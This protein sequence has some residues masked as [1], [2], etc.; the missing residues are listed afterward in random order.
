[1]NKWRPTKLNSLYVIPD[2]HGQL[3]RLK[4]LCKTIL[5]LRKSDG[6]KDQLVFLGDYIDRG[7]KTPEL[8][9]Y[10]IEQKEIHKDRIVLLSGNHEQMFLNAIKQSPTSNKYLFWMNNGGAQTLSAYLDR[11][12]Q[13][14]D[15]PYEL[16]RTRVKDFIPKNHIEFFNS[17]LP[18][19]ETDEFI[20]VHAGCDPTVPLKNQTLEELIW[21]TSLF[22]FVKAQN[23]KDL[24]WNK[25]VVTGH[26]GQPTGEP[27]IS[28]KFLMLDCSYGKKLLLVELH[29][30]KA[31]VAG[32]NK[33]NVVKFDLKS[34]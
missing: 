16:I 34:L 8:I 23:G 12:N 21:D 2:I 17:L 30:M 6:G 5:P 28:D 7:P 33:F 1:M 14:L 9:D 11:A 25:I 27:Y 31:Y 3:D 15:N 32:R 19:Y 29:S 26:H 20:F 18:Y 22:D 4:C 13:H 10:L 24:S